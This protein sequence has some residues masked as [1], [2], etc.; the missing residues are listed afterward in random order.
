MPLTPP[1][2]TCTAADPT[3]NA[4]EQQPQEQPHE[5]EPE[6]I[7]ATP[8]EQPAPEQPEQQ[9]AH[10]TEGIRTIPIPIPSATG[11]P[12]A[13]P[14][15]QQAAPQQ[16]VSQASQPTPPGLRNLVRFLNN[17]EGAMATNDSAYLRAMYSTDQAN[18]VVKSAMNSSGY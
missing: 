14:S 2:H 16:V 13:S 5:Q 9:P 15:Q 6:Q 7:K 12:S 8:N 3:C 17:P 11:R 10:G 1:P 4:Q 18:L